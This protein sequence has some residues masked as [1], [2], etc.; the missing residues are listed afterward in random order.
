[1]ATRKHV[2]MD[3]YVVAIGP[4]KQQASFHWV[5]TDVVEYIL[6]NEMMNDVKII[7]FDDEDDVSGKY[8][9]YFFVK[10]LPSLKT[11]K[12]LQHTKLFFVPIDYFS[13]PFKLTLEA[14]KLQYFHGVLCHSLHL[15]DRLAG[16]APIFHIDH[17]AKFPFNRSLAEHRKQT[18]AWVGVHEYIAS[19]LDY[20]KQYDILNRFENYEF[21]TNINA[22][23]PRRIKKLKQA[24]TA[25]D[26][27]ANIE[28]SDDVLIVNGVRFQQWSEEKQAQV[29]SECELVID[30]K[31]DGFRHQVKPP[32][33]CQ[34][35]ATSGVPVY[36]N[37]IHPAIAQLSNDG[38]AL[39]TINQLLDSNNEDTSAYGQSLR[40]QAQEQYSL[41]NVAKRYSDVI[42]QC[43]S[44]SYR[45]PKFSYLSYWY[46]LK[47]KICGVFAKA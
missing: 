42:H 24:L 30:I 11:I 28:K 43:L 31:Q 41:S 15:A 34:L 35:Y 14:I 12:S 39:R 37:D 4:V 21:L 2:I 7:Y 3:K 25:L 47:A 44:S 5:V 8:D 9:A 33:K 26:L 18:V 38:I 40:E 10:A 20:L 45:P 17:Y 29:I 46:Y 16:V 23:K 22:L 32:T 36:V 13:Y 27:P 6:A 1:M 19:T